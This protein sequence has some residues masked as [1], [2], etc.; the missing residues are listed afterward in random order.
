MN[1]CEKLGDFEVNR[2]HDSQ[3]SEEVGRFFT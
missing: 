1:K 3:D 2:G